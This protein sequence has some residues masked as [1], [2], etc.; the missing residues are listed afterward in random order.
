MPI[1]SGPSPSTTSTGSPR[2]TAAAASATRTVT[3]EGS[4]GWDVTA[5]AQRSGLPVRARRSPVLWRTDR[6]GGYGR[7]MASFNVDRAE[8]AP[9]GG[10]PGFG[11]AAVDIGSTIGAEHLGGTLFEVPPGE[12]ATPYHW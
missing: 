3:A 1:V 9:R 5:S 6:P 7:A 11:S 10:P 12:K 8:P 4:E 2:P